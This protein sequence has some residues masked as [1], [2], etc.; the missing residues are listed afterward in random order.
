MK[1]IRSILLCV[2]CATAWM[3]QAQS[4]PERMTP[5]IVRD[6]VS[7]LS[8][9]QG[10]AIVTNE[11]EP[12]TLAYG[13]TALDAA[14]LSPEFAYLLD[15]YDQQ[16]SQ[17]TGRAL[18]SRARRSTAFRDVPT[19]VTTHWAQ[20]S[21]YNAKCPV[22]SGNYGN[23]CVTGCV[24]TAMA[25]VLNYWKLP[26]VMHGWKAYGFINKAGDQVRQS[27]DFSKQTIDW[28]NMLDKYTGYAST[29]S[30]DAVATL[31]YVCG[32][33]TNMG[34]NPGE[35]SAVAWIGAEAITTL[36]EG[37]TARHSDFDVDLVLEELYAK[38]PV[39][40]CGSAP[41]MGGHCFVV[42]GANSEG[43]LHCN[44]GWGG[45][46]DGYFLPT[47]MAGYRNGQQMVVVHPSDYARVC[48]PIA[49]LRGKTATVDINNFVTSVEPDK[50][51]VLNNSG[52]AGSPYSQGKGLEIVN[53]H[54]LPNNQR[55][56]YNACQL[57]RFIPKG[58]AYYIQTGVGDYFGTFSNGGGGVTTS[59]KS[60]T[61]TL[62]AIENGMGTC[63]IKGNYM[64]DTNGPGST[65][66]GWGTEIPTN[67]YSNSAWLIYPVELSDVES[68]PVTSV[69]F[70]RKNATVFAGEHFD[71][72]PTVL[73]A[74]ASVPQVVWRSTSPS[75]ATVSPEGRVVA[76]AGGTTKIIGTAVDGSAKA[77]TLALR[78]VK[79]TVRTS[80]SKLSKTNLFL[81]QNTGYSQG[82]L[83]TENADATQPTLRGVVTDHENGLYA[84]A[85][86]HEP[87]DLTS[88]CSYWQVRTD[89]DGTQYLFNLG[90]KRY[91]TNGGNET[92]YILV[93]EP[94]PIRLV[95][96]EPE[97]TW[98]INAGTDSKSFL[99]AATHLPN[100]AA[101]WTAEDEGSEWTIYYAANTGFSA[102]DLVGID[103]AQQTQQSLLQREEDT[104]LYSV[105]GARVREGIRPAAGVY[106]RRGRKI[107]LR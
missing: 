18:R 96:S 83:V 57:V 11:A 75:V 24:A 15:L 95:P 105:Q 6:H 37:L 19:L 43:Y 82:Y 87:L 66:V 41:N 8:S 3:A 12:V 81:I 47:V 98:S 16:S 107:I 61:F 67:K 74:N 99:C 56:E 63:W 4:V 2:L 88:P 14:N 68:Q 21:P 62:G 26:K 31:M 77:D 97:A 104:S 30:K 80:P 69:R 29:A 23:P 39:I 51:Y 32:I 9:T 90:T 38:R 44:L 55:T 40:Y 35:S 22:Y 54:N 27:M 86:Y 49:E 20:G 46:G 42:D 71:V 79:T 100:P 28:N 93:D 89:A 76:V 45:D 85:A 1:N 52:R 33:A 84:D 70:D 34:Y 101:Y 64:L 106:V 25:Q 13:G 17:E 36:F 73:P 72:T 65:V 92:C 58:S 50:W 5:I 53:T 10:W 59:T 78:V 102:I 48:T 94:Q 7:V 103:A 60:A 91:L